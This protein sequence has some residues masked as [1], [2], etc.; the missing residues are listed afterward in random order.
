ME[1]H[2]YGFPKSVF[3]FHLNSE[4]TGSL[5]SVISL[6]VGKISGM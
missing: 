6:I 1:I 3:K 5:S 2:S 4:S